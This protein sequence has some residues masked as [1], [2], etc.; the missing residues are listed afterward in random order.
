MITEVGTVKKNGPSKLVWFEV[1]GNLEGQA[2]SHS[3]RHWEM[4]R[5]IFP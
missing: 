5:G 2:L 1:R 3:F 4:A